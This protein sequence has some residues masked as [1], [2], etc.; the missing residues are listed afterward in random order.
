MYFSPFYTFLI[1][2]QKKKKK[3]NTKIQEKQDKKLVLVSLS[4]HTNLEHEE[5]T[6][7]KNQTQNPPS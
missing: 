1:L 5:Y 3:K 7:Q 2:K 6:S 4:L